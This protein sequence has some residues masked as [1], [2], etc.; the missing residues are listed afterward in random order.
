MTNPTLD[1]VGR[2]FS[3]STEEVYDLF[4]VYI[5]PYERKRGRPKKYNTPEEALEARRK[6]ALKYYYDNFEH[7]KHIKK[8][9]LDKK[10]NEKK[11]D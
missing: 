7:C 1:E 8:L 5:S 10:N 9:W 6:T 4:T 3:P 2:A 11:I